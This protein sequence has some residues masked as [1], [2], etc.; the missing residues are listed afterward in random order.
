MRTTTTE[1]SL[2]RVVHLLHKVTGHANS[3]QF[4]SHPITKSFTGNLVVALWVERWV[5]ILLFSDKTFSG[6]PKKE[7]RKMKKKKMTENCKESIFSKAWHLSVK[8]SPGAE[9]AMFSCVTSWLHLKLQICHTMRDYVGHV[10]LYSQP[11][12]LVVAVG[13]V[14]S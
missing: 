5:K 11:K 12:L 7:K 3:E 10:P 9:K 6:I 2:L 14:R 13:V 1:F 8:C 4:C